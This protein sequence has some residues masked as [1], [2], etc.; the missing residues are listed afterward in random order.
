MSKVKEHKHTDILGNELNHNDLVCTIS[1]NGRATGGDISIARFHQPDVRLKGELRTYPRDSYCGSYYTRID[2]C[3]V[4][5]LTE[6]Q[7]NQ[8]NKEA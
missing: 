5:R 2:P 4:L 1:K 8:I 6:E 7:I 3:K